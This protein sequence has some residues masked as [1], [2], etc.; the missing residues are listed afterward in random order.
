[1]KRQIFRG[2]GY[3]CFVIGAVGAVIPLLPTTGPWILAVFFLWKGED[4]LATR[5]MTHPRFGQPLRDWFERGAIRREGKIAACV[6]MTVTVAVMAWLGAPLWVTI[7]VALLLC[8]V[9]VWLVLRPEPQPQAQASP[10]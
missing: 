3:L 6:G 7:G 4:P 2:L 1:M 9:G 10:H 8:G 5:L